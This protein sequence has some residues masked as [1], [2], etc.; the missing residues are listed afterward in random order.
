[1]T[2]LTFYSFLWIIPRAHLAHITCPLLRSS[3]VSLVSLYSLSPLPTLHHNTNTDISLTIFM[4]ALADWAFMGVAL[5][6]G[7][8]AGGLLI[9][10]AFLLLSWATYREMVEERKKK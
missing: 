3:S 7:A 2:D 4:V 1:M 9:I 6:P 8:I 10:G 5:S